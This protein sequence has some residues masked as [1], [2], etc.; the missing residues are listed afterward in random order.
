MDT[1]GIKMLQKASCCVR[2]A[3]QVPYVDFYAP[4][5]YAPVASHEEIRISLATAAPE[6][7]TVEGGDVVNA[8]LYS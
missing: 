4:S 1:V 7:L 3:Y 2:G 6:D 5:L 8:S